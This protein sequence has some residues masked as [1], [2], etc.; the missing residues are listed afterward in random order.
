MTIHFPIFQRL[1]VDGYRLYPGLPNSP[2][3]HLDFTPGPWIVLGVNGLG[4]STLLL[5]LKYVLTGP[6]R[7]RGAGFTG[8]RS[9]VLPVDQRFFAVRVGDSA[10]TAVA[11]AE[12]KFGSAILKVRRRL[13]DLKLVEA[14]VRGVQATDSVTVEEEYRALLAT[15]MGLARFEDALRVLDRVNVLPRVERSIDLGSVG[16]V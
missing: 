15:L 12:I 1:D 13:S 2:G 4:K 10:A 8:D 16:S 11:T 7:I 3:L 14:S 9:D 5:V 6:A